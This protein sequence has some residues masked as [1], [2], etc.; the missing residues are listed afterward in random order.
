MRGG[1]HQPKGSGDGRAAKSSRERM[2]PG[3]ARLEESQEERQSMVKEM[4]DPYWSWRFMRA[5]G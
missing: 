4:L 2:K 1:R 3:P 5:N